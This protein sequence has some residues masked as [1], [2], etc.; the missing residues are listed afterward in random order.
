MTNS[1]R[2]RRRRPARPGDRCLRFWLRYQGRI[3]RFLQ[4]TDYRECERGGEPRYYVKRITHRRWARGWHYFG[5][6]S[7]QPHLEHY[8]RLPADEWVELVYAEGGQ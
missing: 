8:A 7:W 6:Q 2:P 4:V 5:A 3:L 1:I